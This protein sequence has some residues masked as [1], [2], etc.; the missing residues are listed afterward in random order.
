[1]NELRLLT[2]ADLEQITAIMAQ[3]FCADP[4]W[5]YVVPQIQ[6]RQATLAK[7]FRGLVRLYIRNQQG[8]GVGDPLQ[9]V[10]IWSVPHQ[11]PASPLALLGFETFKLLLT[12]GIWAVSKRSLQVARATAALKKKY[13]HEPH[14][15]LEALAVAPEAQRQGLASKLVRPF[16]AQAAAQSLNVYLDTF[17]EANVR[18]YEHYGFVCRERWNV[19]ELGLPLWLLQYSAQ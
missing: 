9:G 13:V 2:P 12:P 3:A 4:A 17:N 8:Y 11:H 18:I 16:L 7:L 1:M 15:Y 19:P 6:H 14:Y 5:T 10:A